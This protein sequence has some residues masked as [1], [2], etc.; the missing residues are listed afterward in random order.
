MKVTIY[1]FNKP[2]FSEMRS[3]SSRNSV[4]HCKNL[5]LVDAAQYAMH[6]A[7]VY[8][9]KLINARIPSLTSP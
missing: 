5:V 6:S 8:F 7:T 4:V 3:I 9:S 1:L 2:S